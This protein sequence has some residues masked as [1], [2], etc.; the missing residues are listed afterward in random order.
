V[1]AES[2]KYE[3]TEGGSITDKIGSPSQTTIPFMKDFVGIKDDIDHH[4]KK[5]L[6]RSLSSAL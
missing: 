6:G 4:L 2:D 3:A 1:P 5:K